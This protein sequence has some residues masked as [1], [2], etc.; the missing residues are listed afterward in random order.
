MRDGGRVNPR[1]GL[2]KC[3][4]RGYVIEGSRMTV[5]IERD[6]PRRFLVRCANVPAPFFNSE[7]RLLR[8]A[9]A[10]AEFEAGLL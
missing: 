1:K 10:E 4:Y 3:G 9:R 5:Y 6:R 7:H 2:K 8:D